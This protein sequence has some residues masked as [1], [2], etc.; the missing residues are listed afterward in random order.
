MDSEERSDIQRLVAYPEESVG[1]VMTSDFAVLS[2][3]YTVEQAMQKLRSI[4]EQNRNHLSGL[5]GR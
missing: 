5:C 4:A 3:D 2:A 1:A